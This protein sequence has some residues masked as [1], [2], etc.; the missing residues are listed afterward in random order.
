MPT[1]PGRRP[2]PAARRRLALAAASSP[3]SPPPAP[4]RHAARGR[5]A[6]APLP[7]LPPR[8]PP[9]AAPAAAPAPP[10]H[11]RILSINDFHGQLT[12]TTSAGRPVGGGAVLVS[13]LKAEAAELPATTLIVHAG[14]LVGASPPASALLQ[15]EPT[16]ALFDLLGNSRCH[17]AGEAAPARA[18]R[19]PP[20][21]ATT[22]GP[23][24]STRA[25]TW[26]PPSATTSWTRGATSCCACS[27]AGTTGRGP[28]LEKPWRG[29]RYP[30]LS[31]NVVETPA[32]ARCS[33]PTS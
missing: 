23:P 21:R 32:A 4:G 15:D 12:P 9:P 27:A 13:Y 5:R 6:A 16:V 30:T 19:R 20:T 24:G 29:A 28:F 14:D 31:A 7:S 18:C 8:P 17:R 3:R 11:A 25:A 2:L 10:V 33:R 22:A 26:P 1:A